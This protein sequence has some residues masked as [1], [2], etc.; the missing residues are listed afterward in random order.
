VC[1]DGLLPIQFKDPKACARVA[2]EFTLRLTSDDA[3]AV[4]GEARCERF[5][6]A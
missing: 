3:K 2:E 5:G 4:V 1:A 6:D